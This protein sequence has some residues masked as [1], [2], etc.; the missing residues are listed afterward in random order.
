MRWPQQAAPLGFFGWNRSSWD[1][2]LFPWW[3]KPRAEFQR[4][5][6]GTHRGRYPCHFSGPS[7]G[8]VCTPLEAGAE[9]PGLLRDG[10]IFQP[11]LA[12]SYVHHRDAGPGDLKMNL[13]AP[14]P[15]GASQHG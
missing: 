6:F 9:S 5:R 2:R 4:W 15:Q 11:A 8:E 13:L 12:C 10:P 7:L 1:P 3:I 14:D